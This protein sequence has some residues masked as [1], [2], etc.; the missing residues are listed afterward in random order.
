VSSSR[1][2]TTQPGRWARLRARSGRLTL[3]L[4]ASQVTLAALASRAS[5]APAPSPSP[6]GT[7]TCT[8]VIPVNNCVPANLGPGGPAT[9]ANTNTGVLPSLNPLHDIANACVQGAN[10]VI[11]K[12]ADGV[13][14][15]TQV[16]FTNQGFLTQY[17]VVFAAATFLTLVL[18]LLAVAKRAARGVPVQQAFAEA[19][20]FLWLTVIASAFTPLALYVMVRLTDAV[21]EAIASGTKANTVRFFQGFS[22]A[23]DPS[24]MD[25]LGGPIMVIFVSL[26]ALAAAAILWLELLIRAAMLYVGA[27][28]GTAV[29]AGL[30]DKNMWGH[31]RRWAGMMI[32]ID[33][34]KPVIVI[35]LGLAAAITGNGGPTDAFS[36]VL[37]G[38]AILFLSIFASAIIYRFVPNF[39]DDMA[40]LHQHRRT[41][42]NAGPAAVVNGPATFMRQGIAAHASR[43][44]S[45]PASTATAS[46]ISSGVTAHGSRA[47]GP[48]TESAQ[49]TQ[50]ALRPTPPPSRPT[51]PPA[52]PRHAKPPTGNQ[53]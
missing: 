27:I 1:D 24:N 10:W 17:A 23:L 18:W 26:L 38:L 8:T 32:A 11:S 35:V 45:A 30:V 9:P 13:N 52:G 3:L 28:L 15:I 5:A 22:H 2:A 34:A 37:S 42:A 53:P 51:L 16:D 44:A 21:T 33:L 39:G 20:G 47:V 43:R 36:S 31:V 40:A 14:S 12:L 7:P 46:A 4:I 25:A 50:P 29:Y 6:S 41:A 19:V 49:T 48:G